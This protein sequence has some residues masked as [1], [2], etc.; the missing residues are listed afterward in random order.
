M[1]SALPSLTSIWHT[2]RDSGKTCQCLQGRLLYSQ[3]IRCLTLHA[4]T[5]G[6]SIRCQAPVTAQRQATQASIQA[7]ADKHSFYASDETTFA[8][9]GLQA[10]LVDALQSMGYGRPSKVQ[11]YSAPRHTTWH[12][13]EISMVWL[14]KRISA[15]VTGVVSPIHPVWKVSCPSGRNWQRKDDGLSCSSDLLPSLWKGRRDQ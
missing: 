6:R 1:A 12:T 13:G 2:L 10:S 4:R 5:Y 9:L 7:T 14:L 11:V 3:E 8:S 15:C